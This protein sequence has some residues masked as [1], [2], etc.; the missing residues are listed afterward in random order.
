L[1]HSKP[2]YCVV[3]NKE[4]ENVILS[5]SY[6]CQAVVF[7]IDTDSFKEIK[8]NGFIGSRKTEKKDILHSDI[9]FKTI[10]PMPVF[11]CSWCYPNSNYFS[12]GCQDGIVR[13]FDYVAGSQ[14]YR[15]V[16]SSHMLYLF[17]F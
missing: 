14:I 15:Y 9:R 4:A 12:T 17:L 2:I 7:K 6:D 13:I 5:T 3:W 8:T 11:G 16:N 10:H 1:H